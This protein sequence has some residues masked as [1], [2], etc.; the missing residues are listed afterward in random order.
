MKR[1]T[2][3]D[4]PQELLDLY[5][6]RSTA[7]GTAF[8]PDTAWQR[9]LETLDIELLLNDLAVVEKKIEKLSEGLKKGI[10]KNDK[11][12]AQKELALFERLNESLSEERPLRDLD[13]SDEELKGLRGYS[14]LTLKPVMVVVSTSVPTARSWK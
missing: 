9:D 12:E 2:A 3:N 8:S 4:F 14:L 1:K 5:A 10:F 6:K 7:R 13:L 11:T